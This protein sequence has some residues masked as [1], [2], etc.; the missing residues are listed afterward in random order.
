MLV[1]LTGLG[2]L[3]YPSVSDWWNSFHQSRA[4]TGYIEAVGKLSAEEY[5]R[6]W[7]D[8]TEYNQ[9]LLRGVQSFELTP[10]QMADYDSQLNIEGNGIMGY[11]EVPVINV[12]LPLYHGVSESVL[13]VAIGHIPGSSLPVG[14]DS[15][16]CV[17]SGHRGLPSARLFTDLDKVQEG[18]LF[19]FHTLQETLTY[20]VDQ[21][22]I[23]E[24]ED[25]QDLMITRGED[26]ATLVTCTPY[27]INSHRMLVRGHRVPNVNADNLA[28]EAE[29]VNPFI[30]A[31]AVGIPVMFVILVIALFVTRRRPEVKL[32]Q[33]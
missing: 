22:R 20:E 15:T 5:E 7:N 17:V 2:L 24:P 13:Q 12:K 14:G 25:T 11:V 28:A 19:M 29:Q 8:A 33:M 9:S 16:H 10:T 21:I 30:V 26:L 31:A 27:G 32:S 4:I 6:V 1:L 23:V 18:D 3:A